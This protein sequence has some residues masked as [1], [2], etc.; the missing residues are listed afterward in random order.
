MFNVG[1]D[2]VY[3]FDFNRLRVCFCFR[4]CYFTQDGCD[5]LNRSTHNLGKG[6]QTVKI[7]DEVRVPPKLQRGRKARMSQISISSDGNR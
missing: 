6:K 1:L 2:H 5:V 3:L 4:S 7:E